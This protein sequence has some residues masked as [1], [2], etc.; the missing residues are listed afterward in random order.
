LH[1]R[2]Q[3]M[4]ESGGVAFARPH[5]KCVHIYISQ[6][7]G[8]RSS[9]LETGT[10]PGPGWQVDG[11]QGRPLHLLH[12]GGGSRGSSSDLDEENHGYRLGE[13]SA[14]GMERAQPGDRPPQASPSTSTTASSSRAAAASSL[15]PL[16]RIRSVLSRSCQHRAKHTRN[17]ECDTN[18]HPHAYAQDCHSL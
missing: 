14:L 9:P 11:L 10:E 15:L 8:T 3:A 1:P 6:L 18:Q 5:E 7:P 4:Y 2:H 13:G 16:A 12:T 17:A